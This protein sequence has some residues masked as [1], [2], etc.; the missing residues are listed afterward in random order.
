MLQA[1]GLSCAPDPRSAPLFTNIDISLSPGEKVALV[2][3][4][5]C[6]KSMLMRIL[7]GQLRPATGQVVLESGVTIAY[8][9]QDFGSNF[10]GSLL[11]LLGNMVPG[12]PPHAVARALYRFDLGQH[13]LPRPFAHLSLGERTRGILAALLATEPD[14]LLLDEPTN[15]LDVETRAWFE[16]FLREATE[17]VLFICHDRATVNAV[18]DRVVELDH[19]GLHEY[20]GG[21]DDMAA[22]KA[23]TIE[24]AQAQWESHRTES[25]RL[26]HAAEA[27]AQRAVKASA[28]P[29]NLSNYN[30]KAKPFYA[31]KQARMDR[32]SKAMLER[33]ARVRDQSPDKPYIAAEPSLA[34][35]TR[36]LRSAQP[37]TARRLTKRFG[38]RVL[39]DDLHVTLERGDRL[40]VTGP[41]GMGKSTLLRIL[42]GEESAEGG[43]I[44]WAPDAKPAM[45]SQGRDA[46]DLRLSAIAALDDSTGFARNA[47]GRL[48]MRGPVA[49]RPLG[50]LSMGE[51][52]K[53]EIVAM[54]LAGANVLILDEP[55]NHLD[56]P[57]VEALEEALF[58]FPGAIL[59]TSHDRRFVEALATSVLE[60][61]GGAL[62]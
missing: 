7:A 59:F 6:G 11:E 15:H 12:A 62:E 60:L 17:A 8:L 38:E 18:A 46:L 41:N 42:T 61:A 21:Y 40:A 34:F 1:F 27:T 56:L 19:D 13:L 47:L 14:I 37:L 36:V 24:R 22:M 48:G 58:S 3:R 49:E 35:P 20:A 52:T 31:A 30:P 39:F 50:V 33:A 2:G 43:E 57:S 26:Q 53:V 51:R 54:M 44:V 29:K 25:R 32:V 10:P 5:G 23:L 4:N 16:A 45:L 55:T 9:P 28:K